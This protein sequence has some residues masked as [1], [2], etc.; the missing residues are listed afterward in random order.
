MTPVWLAFSAGIGLA[1]CFFGGLW[2]TV[3]R[4]PTARFPA[5]L[6]VTSA[7]LRFGLCFIGFYLVMGEHWDR[8]LACVLGF[9][10]VQTVWLYLS[11]RSLREAEA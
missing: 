5:F 8:L 4:L 10:A 9:A 6:T 3:Q 7:C 2:I 11:Q 1:L